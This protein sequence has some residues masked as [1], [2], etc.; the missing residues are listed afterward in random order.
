MKTAH[1]I[2]AIVCVC[3]SGLEVFIVNSGV[4]VALIA[5]KLNSSSSGEQET[6]TAINT[7]THTTHT[8]APSLDVFPSK[9]VLSHFLDQLVD[10]DAL[11]QGAA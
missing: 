4:G 11:V 1:T 10:A 7:H 5:E 8:A 3:V 6:D 9:A 2:I